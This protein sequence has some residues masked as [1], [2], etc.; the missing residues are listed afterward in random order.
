MDKTIVTFQIEYLPRQNHQ[1]QRLPV[2]KDGKPE[3]LRHENIPQEHR[4]TLNTAIMARNIKIP[5]K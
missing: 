1:S 4:A 5:K 3:N 2:V